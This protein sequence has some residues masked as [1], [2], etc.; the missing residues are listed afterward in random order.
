[1]IIQFEKKNRFYIRSTLRPK[2]YWYFNPAHGRVEISKTRQSKFTITRTTGLKYA[3]RQEED[4]LIAEDDVTLSVTLNGGQ[5]QAQRII[6]T[7]DQMNSLVPGNGR[8][9][10]FKFWLFENGFYGMYDQED[11]LVCAANRPEVG[12]KWE[13]VA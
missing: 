6:L 10:S 5:G 7:R 1:M 11:G 8:G 3:V 13:F 4:I 9:S 2:Y 12:E